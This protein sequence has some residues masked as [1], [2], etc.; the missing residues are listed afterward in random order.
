[1]TLNDLPLKQGLDAKRVL[2]L[3][4]RPKELALRRVLPWLAAERPDLFNAYQQ[5][6]SES[7]EAAM[8]KAGYVAS[9][10]GHQPG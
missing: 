2:V 7:V 8:Q 5:F 3:R 6:Q 4:H 9:F 10:V 1:M